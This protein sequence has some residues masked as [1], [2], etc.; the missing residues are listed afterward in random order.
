MSKL[1]DDDGW[2]PCPDWENPFLEEESKKPASSFYDR[3]YRPK[4][5]PSP[6][7][8]NLNSPLS[9]YSYLDKHVYKQD[10]WKKTASVVL[11]EHLQ[12]HT[13]TVT[14]VNG[15]PGCGKSLV[16]ETLREICT[17]IIVV[18]SANLT[19]SGWSGEAKLSDVISRAAY[20]DSP[21]ICFDEFDKLCQPQFSRTENVSASMQSE[22]LKVFDGVDVTCKDGNNTRIARTSQFSFILLGSFAA[23][24]EEIS[25]RKSSPGIGFLSTK[26]DYKQ[27]QEPL[28]IQDL[29]DFG[30]IPEIASRITR[31]TAVEP[32]SQDDYLYLLTKHPESPVKKLEKQYGVRLGLSKADLEQMAHD[33]YESGLGIRHCKY[34]IQKKVDER[35]FEKF[36]KEATPIAS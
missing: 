12:G 29:I 4:P 35:I 30:V 13:G 1:D 27:F 10:A 21:I 33:A 23:K 26:D 11:Y 15:P 9:I 16:V 20:F 32:L 2:A 31:M 8:C 5:R 22:L 3:S 14:L 28:T 36:S 7:K 6:K 25:E 34:L 17:K 19:K 18:N 24:A